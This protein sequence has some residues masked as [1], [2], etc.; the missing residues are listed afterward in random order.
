MLNK[1]EVRLG[2]DQ[3]SRVAWQGDDGQGAEDGVHG[4]A[5]EPELPEMR[6][7][8]ERSRRGEQLGGGTV[9]TSCG[10]VLGLSALLL[11]FCRRQR[12]RPLDLELQ[13]VRVHPRHLLNVSDKSVMRLNAE[14]I[15]R[16]GA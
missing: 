9:T 14:A 7:A 5:F 16:I 8:Q 15:G 6:A 11:A 4:S 1:L 10:G 12:L 3:W 13:L 2:A